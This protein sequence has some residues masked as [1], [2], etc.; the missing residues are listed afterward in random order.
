MQRGEIRSELL[1]QHAQLRSQSA[2]LEVTAERCTSADALHH[3]RHALVELLGT[4][5]A[6]NAYEEALMSEV[7]PELD[8]W[9][10]VRH[11]V[12]NEAHAAE[13]A[14]M[15]AALR[16]AVVERDV[17]TAAATTLRMLRE[18]SAHMEREE[19]VFLHPDV[20]SDDVSTP[21]SFGG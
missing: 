8:G 10:P 3:L 5:R 19:E 20:L 6:H 2:A 15:E 17:A 11:E 16:T 18:L 13:H 4:L 9:G 14:K 7:F 1:H 12:M 21:D